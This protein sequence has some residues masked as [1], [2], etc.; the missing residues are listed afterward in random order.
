MPFARSDD[1]CCCTFLFFP[2]K[3][4]LFRSLLREL[5][6][7]RL[8]HRPHRHSP[9]AVKRKMSNYNTITRAKRTSVSYT[10]P[11]NATLS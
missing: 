6:E 4:K 7:E 2:R 3:K 8:R 5:A 11:M 10:E 1:I 9:R